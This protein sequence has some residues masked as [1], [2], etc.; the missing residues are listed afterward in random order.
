MK[1]TEAAAVVAGSVMALGAAT[2]AMA[3][4]VKSD[5]TPTIVS[6]ATALLEAGAKFAH[7]AQDPLDGVET[8]GLTTAT[9]KSAQE[10]RAGQDSGAAGREITGQGARALAMLGGLPIG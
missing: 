2:P 5:S 6:D 8:E 7:S 1:Y 3:M 9:T 4:E 10:L